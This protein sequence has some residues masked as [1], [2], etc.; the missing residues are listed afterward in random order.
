MGDTLGARCVLSVR[1]QE[2][3]MTQ[4]L[5]EKRQTSAGLRA[6]GI[7][8]DQDRRALTQNCAYA[9]NYAY[10]HGRDKGLEGAV[11]R[12]SPVS[13]KGQMCTPEARVRPSRARFRECP[14]MASS[15]LLHLGSLSSE[16]VSEPPGPEDQARVAGKNLSDVTFTLFKHTNINLKF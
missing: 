3:P 7:K 4:S 9:R 14:T 12:S 16:G 11:P 15:L 10:K 6:Q 1:C 13:G 5:R 8:C 2:V